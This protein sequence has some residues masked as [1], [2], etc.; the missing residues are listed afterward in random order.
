M[1]ESQSIFWFGLVYGS[2]TSVLL[3]RDKLRGWGG[4]GEGGREQRE[5]PGRQNE[6]EHGRVAIG[7]RQALDSRT[8]KNVQSQLLEAGPNGD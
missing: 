6:T 1:Y 7:S 8:L 2:P 5:V 4:D 3:K